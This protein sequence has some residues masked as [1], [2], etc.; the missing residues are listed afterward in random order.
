[1][2]DVRTKFTYVGEIVLGRFPRN[3]KKMV[4]KELIAR[5]QRKREIQVIETIC[6]FSLQKYGKIIL[7]QQNSYGWQ[8]I[9]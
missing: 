1:M 6:T 8:N 5:D 4:Y 3:V 7:L 2:E 9:I